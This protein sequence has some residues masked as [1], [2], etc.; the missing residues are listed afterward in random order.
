MN[1]IGTAVG[2]YQARPPGRF[3]VLQCPHAQHLQW[4]AT[5]LT[6]IL[7][8]KPIRQAV[9]VLNLVC[10]TTVPSVVRIAYSGQLIASGVLCLRN[11]DSAVEVTVSA[12]IV[13]NL[14]LSNNQHNAIPDD[15][16]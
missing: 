2:G 8:Q 6:F 11:V 5:G 7:L 14:P 9:V 13:H 15:V 12:A 1:K 16:A 10:T 4:Q 3:L